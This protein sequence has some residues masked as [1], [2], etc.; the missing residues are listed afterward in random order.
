MDKHADMKFVLFLECQEETMIERISKRADE[1]GEE[2]R[3]ND[4]NLEVL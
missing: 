2:N 3:R 4:D 1:A